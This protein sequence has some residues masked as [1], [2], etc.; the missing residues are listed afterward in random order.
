[1]AS[2]RRAD[3][4]KWRFVWGS[5]VAAS[6]FEDTA[7]VQLQGEPCGGVWGKPVDVD[8]SSRAIWV[9]CEK[10]STQGQSRVELVVFV[11]EAAPKLCETAESAPLTITSKP[12]TVTCRA[13]SELPCVLQV[14]YDSQIGVV[15]IERLDRC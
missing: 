6:E 2:E 5:K 8:A 3:F 14:C 15:S 9:V 1:M 4:V 11:F 10:E 13:L 12:S 7:F